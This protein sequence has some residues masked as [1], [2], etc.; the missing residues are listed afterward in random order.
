MEVEKVEK[1]VKA[2]VDEIQ[3]V[4]S[5]TNIMGEPKVVEGATL[6]PL[7]ST[8][9]MFGAGGGTGVEQT[10]VKGEAWGGGTGGGVGIRPVALVIIDQSGIRVEAIRGALGSAIEKI[11]EKAPEVMGQVISKRKESRGEKKEG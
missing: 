3:K 5:T 11:A 6:I 9:F 10:K 8:G 4:L 2:S 1:M 7:L